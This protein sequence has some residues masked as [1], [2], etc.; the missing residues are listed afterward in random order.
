VAQRRDLAETYDFRMVPTTFLI[1][2]EGRVTK[3]LVGQKGKAAL[4]RAFRELVGS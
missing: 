2:E 3:K 1:D 4:D